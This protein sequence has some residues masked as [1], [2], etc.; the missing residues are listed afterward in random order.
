MRLDA[1]G[2][3]KRNRSWKGKSDAIDYSLREL[4]EQL[5]FQEVEFEEFAEVCRNFEKDEEG[6]WHNPSRGGRIVYPPHHVFLA[7]DTMIIGNHFDDQINAFADLMWDIVEYE[8]RFCS[9]ES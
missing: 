2:R 8:E 3:K 6:V 5:G 9:P 4:L 7:R 1:I